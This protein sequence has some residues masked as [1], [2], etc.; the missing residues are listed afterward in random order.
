VKRAAFGQSPLPFTSPLCEGGPA[1]PASLLPFR[2]HSSSCSG[3]SIHRYT[4]PGIGRHFSNPRP[5]REG[6]GPGA[7]KPIGHDGQNKLTTI[8]TKSFCREQYLLK[9]RAGLAQPVRRSRHTR[10]AC[11]FY[12]LVPTCLGRL[13][14]ARSSGQKPPL[15]SSIDYAAETACHYGGDLAIVDARR[16]GCALEYLDRKIEL[17]SIRS[18]LLFYS[19]RL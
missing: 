3:P 11:Y 17:K 12:L 15:C 6:Y 7:P 16:T 4:A 1:F 9:L 14:R 13:G 5:M 10:T 19:I 8:Q 18:S 2:P